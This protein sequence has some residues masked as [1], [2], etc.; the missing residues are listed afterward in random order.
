MRELTPAE[1]EQIADRLATGQFGSALATL[2]E[3]AMM[4]DPSQPEGQQSTRLEVWCRSAAADPETHAGLLEALL[5][6][7]AHRAACT[8]ADTLAVLRALETLIDTNWVSTRASFLKVESASGTPYY[9]LRKHR[10]RPT[11]AD[12]RPYTLEA[13]LSRLHVVARQQGRL[14][15]E[16]V[17]LD[18]LADAALCPDIEAPRGYVVH[19][20]PMP[21]LR[22]DEHDDAIQVVAV[23]DESGHRQSAL[24]HIDKAA[25]AT[26]VVFPE[27]TMP[28]SCRAAVGSRLATMGTEAPRLTLAGSFHDP[29]VV[30]AGPCLNRGVLFDHRGATLLAHVKTLT[31]SLRASDGR[32][33][34][35]YIRT[36]NT[37][38]ALHT[39]LGLIGV[40]ICIEFSDTSAQP[41]AAWAAVAPQ[42]MLVPSMGEENTCDMHRRAAEMLRDQHRTTTL[43][44]NQSPTGGQCPGFVVCADASLTALVNSVTLL[45][46]R[47]P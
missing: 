7:D 2:A 16:L 20:D 32:T 8:S 36:H 24:D 47:T 35:E 43:V 28:A 25:G 37:M 17:A 23:D 29:D 44:A 38:H 40:A 41:H 4:S 15:L 33:V 11:R 9:I 46:K 27:C 18:H 12:R 14:Q 6:F 30:G 39:S 42:W 1:R 34:A 3:W 26:F 10:N 19:F 45:R 5:D 21:R 22:M 31:A 13:V